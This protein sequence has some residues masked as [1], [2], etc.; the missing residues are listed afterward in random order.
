[1][2]EKGLNNKAHI[3][4]L[5]TNRQ[6]TF[7]ARKNKM[8]KQVT[9]AKVFPCSRSMDAKKDLVISCSNALQH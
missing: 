6:Q 3:I 8:A 7:K 2:V 4:R 9:W 5:L 1:M